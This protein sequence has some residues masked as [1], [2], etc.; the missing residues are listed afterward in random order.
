[1]SFVELLWK[2]EVYKIQ[3]AIYEVYKEIDTGFLETVYQESLE[4]GLLMSK[5]PFI[6]KK[7]L[8]INLKVI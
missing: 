1:M 5:I 4:E 3:G 6:A 8:S 2:E 7:E